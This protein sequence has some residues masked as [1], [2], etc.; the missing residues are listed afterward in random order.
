MAPPHP[1]RFF[2]IEFREATPQDN[3]RR[4]YPTADK[5]LEYTIGLSS[6]TGPKY[7]TSEGQI[8]IEVPE[9][10]REAV[11]RHSKSL[12]GQKEV[13]YIHYLA[14]KPKKGG[15]VAVRIEAYPKGYLIP[16]G[17]PSPASVFSNEAKGLGAWLEARLR[18]HVR[19]QGITHVMNSGS[20]WRT[21]ERQMENAELQ[22][23]KVHPVDDWFDGMER[24][25]KKG[26]EKLKAG[27]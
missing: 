15:S 23:D 13:G 12:K 4:S 27:L 6:E 10:Y 26:L 11:E 1:P 18:E 7:S 22:V 8:R 19:S 21:A 25:A 14:L 9:P 16:G 2:S 3:H 24:A 5:V 20:M 17:A